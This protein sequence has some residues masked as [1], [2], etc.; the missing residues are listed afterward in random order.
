[1]LYSEGVV[2]GQ[3]GEAVGQLS[4]RPAERIVLVVG[5]GVLD[6]V[7]ADDFVVAVAV[8]GLPTKEIDLTEEPGERLEKH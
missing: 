1:M 8:V 3:E 5:L 6:V 2:G 7:A 4:D